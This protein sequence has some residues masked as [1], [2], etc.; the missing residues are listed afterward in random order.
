[1]SQRFQMRIVEGP[2]QG[3]W[4][5]ACVAGPDAGCT[6]VFFGTV[7]DSGR[8]GKVV[9]LDYEL[10][11]DMVAKEFASI[12]AETQARFSILRI[13][14][15]HSVGRV[16]VGE[17]SVAVAIAAAHRKDVFAAADYIMA[18]LKSRVPIWKKEVCVDGSE[19]R[20]QGS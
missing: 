10:Y 5:Q 13:A 7:R 4:A 20:G 3:G 8:L 19:W 16:A 17:G 1:M 15:E 9:H 12:A 6:L 11:P 14:L 18:E 2:V